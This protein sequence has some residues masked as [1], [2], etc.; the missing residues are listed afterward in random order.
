MI[1]KILERVDEE[2]FDSD[3]DLT[4]YNGVP[5]TGI[6]FDPFPSGEGIEYETTYKDGLPHGMSRKWHS[7]GKLAYEV[8]CKNG[9]VHGKETYWYPDGS[10]KSEAIYE[11]GIKISLKAW[12]EQGQL[13]EEFEID[14]GST[15][16][17]LLQKYRRELV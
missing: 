2:Y 1:E 12:D 16:Y 3:G 14:P 15:N 9:A 4:L 17:A 10:V 8:E 7:S 6:G 13:I 11:Y 5:F